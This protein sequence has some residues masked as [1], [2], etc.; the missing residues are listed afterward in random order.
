MRARHQNQKRLLLSLT[1]TLRKYS[2]PQWPLPKHLGTGL[3]AAQRRESV[4][5]CTAPG[6]NILWHAGWRRLLAL[7]ICDPEGTA[8]K[9]ATGRPLNELPALIAASRFPS[10]PALIP[11]FRSVPN[12]IEHRK[13]HELRA[14]DQGS[15]PDGAGLV[16]EAPE[17]FQSRPAGP[18]GTHDGQ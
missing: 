5:S 17:P 7:G 6:A 2:T 3:T 12:Q 14:V 11:W 10:A 8:G 16:Q 4:R 1:R 15:A 18:V 13:K 9:P